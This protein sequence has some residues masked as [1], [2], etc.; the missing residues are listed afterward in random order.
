MSIIT[1]SIE[2]LKTWSSLSLDGFKSSLWNAFSSIKSRGSNWLS[3]V[4]TTHTSKYFWAQTDAI[5]SDVSYRNINSF[6]EAFKTLW[7][8]PKALISVPLRYWYASLQSLG[9]ST[10][11]LPWQSTK[12][13][14][15][16]TFDSTKALVGVWWSLGGWLLGWVGAW[17][18]SA[19]TSVISVITSDSSIP[20]SDKLA[21]KKEEKK[22]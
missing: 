1:P 4:V 12:L 11:Q 18:K 10:L 8:K 2:A 15:W 7:T 5:K 21:E 19:G 14:W 17:L 20:K 6:S 16:S 3:N 13:I 22:S 9:M